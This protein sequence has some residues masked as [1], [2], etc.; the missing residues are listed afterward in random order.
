MRPLLEMRITHSQFTLDQ[1]IRK[2][3]TVL[4]IIL[5]ILQR[6]D[7]V[8]L[9]RLVRFQGRERKGDSS[10]PTASPSNHDSFLPMWQAGTRCNR[11]SWR[12]RCFED[13]YDP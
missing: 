9:L 2:E 13:D 1:H 7:E 8:Y 12:I 3:S 5:E 10:A 4:K 6:E 11:R